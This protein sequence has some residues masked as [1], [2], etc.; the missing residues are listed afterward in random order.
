MVIFEYIIKIN[1]V[2]SMYLKLALK[3]NIFLMSF[4]SIYLLY[5][6]TMCINDVLLRMVLRLCIRYFKLNLCMLI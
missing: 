1:Q 2:S 5:I 3:N 6:A 4:Y